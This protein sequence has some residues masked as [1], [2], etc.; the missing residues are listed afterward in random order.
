MNEETR[1]MPDHA[2]E[3][4]VPRRKPPGPITA[5]IPQSLH[6]VTQSIWFRLRIPAAVFLL[7][8]LLRM[9][10]LMLMYAQQTDADLLYLAPDCRRYVQ[11]GTYLAGLPYEGPPLDWHSGPIYATPEGSIL[12]SGPGYGLF[13]AA[14]FTL[15]G[16]AALPVVI[17]QILLGGVNCA[18]IYFLARALGFDRR[19]GALAGL[20]A[21]CSLTSISLSCMILTE[22]LFFTL[23]LCGLL[24]LVLAY[25]RERWRGFIFAGLL[26]AAGTSVRGV[27]LLWPAVMVLLAVL[28]PA[29]FFA[30]SRRR[31]LVKSLTG[32][33]VMCC[34]LGGWSLRNYIKHDLPAFS[35]GGAMAARYFWTARTLASLDPNIN[36]RGMQHKME[37]ETL[38][39]YGPDGTTFAEHHRE[40]MEVFTTAL[41]EHPWP[42]AKRFVISALQNTTRGSEL[43][44]HQLPQFH[45]FWD[46]IKPFIHKKAGAVLLALTVLGGLMLIS[47]PA[48]RGAGLILA[49]T[50]LY[51][52]GIT[53]FEFWQGSRVCNPAQMAW[54]ILLAVVIDRCLNLAGTLYRRA[55]RGRRDMTEK[56]LA[57]PR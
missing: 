18:L 48:R 28:L 43:H 39:R 9:L 41:R 15:F 25:Q 30:G 20:I 13:L 52:C 36:T 35:E 16:T 42:M 4:L 26:F 27:T 54:A 8:I 44:A 56:D 1:V 6:T 10:W 3:T 34:L 53:G 55:R 17:G 40:N 51:L 31:L 37:A 33:A 7:A 50:Y 46:R 22:T 14:A 23:Q 57:M 38:A 12:W 21:A 2:A 24:C 11:I 47:D 45:V 32:A 5:T 29:R 19:I 49:G